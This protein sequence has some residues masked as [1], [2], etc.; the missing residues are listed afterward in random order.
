MLKVIAK[1]YYTKEDYLFLEQ[2]I[3][4]GFL[5]EFLKCDTRDKKCRKCEYQKACKDIKQFIDYLGTIN[6]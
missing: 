5:D 6:R 1:N 4:K 3:R 2:V